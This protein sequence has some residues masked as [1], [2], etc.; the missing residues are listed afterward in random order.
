MVAKLPSE[1]WL[2]FNIALRLD[3]AYAILM[4]PLSFSLSLSLSLLLLPNPYLLPCIQS[5][6]KVFLLNDHVT[7]SI[8]TSPRIVTKHNMVRAGPDSSPSKTIITFI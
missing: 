5:S 4:F 6:S 1:L 2:S 8:P 3:L 7:I